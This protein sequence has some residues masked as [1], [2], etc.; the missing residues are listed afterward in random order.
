MEKPEFFNE[1]RKMDLAPGD[2]VFLRAALTSM[3]TPHRRSIVDWFIEFLGEDGTLLIPTYTGA[4]FV[5][6]KPYPI[7]DRQAVPT[8]GSL[9]KIAVAH[10]D[11]RRSEHPTHSFVCFGK[12]TSFLLDGHDENAP[13]HLPINRLVEL[14]GK[15]VVIG[16]SAECPGMSTSHAAQFD[17]GLSQ[18]HYIRHF[19]RVSIR[20]PDGTLRTWKPIE[21]PGCSCKFDRFY[22][23]YIRTE[24]FQTGRIAGAYTIISKAKAAYDAEIQVLKRD[25]LIGDCGRYDCLTCSFRGYHKS[26]ILFSVVA[27]PWKSIKYLLRK[28]Q[29]RTK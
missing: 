19:Q 14:D 21:A 24:N 13:T 15:M 17:L 23:A 2:T 5:S 16:C 6:R 8:I 18:Q 27:I 26:R 22:P 10:P 12:H 29:E 3:N 1:L 4:G 11:G 9:S 20:N 7:F 25:P 28:P